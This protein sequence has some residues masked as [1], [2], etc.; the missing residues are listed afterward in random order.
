[1]II[2]FNALRSILEVDSTLQ[3]IS[4][5]FSTGN[6]L[7]LRNQFIEVDVRDVLVSGRVHA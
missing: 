7:L 3:S 2:V 4:G 6:V 1:M 5:L